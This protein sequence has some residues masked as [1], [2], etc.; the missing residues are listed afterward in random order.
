M[1]G[2]ESDLLPAPE[3]LSRRRESDEPRDRR[4][5]P[6]AGLDDDRP[7]RDR[8]GQ[9]TERGAGEPRASADLRPRDERHVERPE[10]TGQRDACEGRRHDPGGRSRCAR[11][12][13]DRE[14]DAGVGR[15]Q[16]RERCRDQTLA[17]EA[18]HVLQT[19]LSALANEFGVI[20]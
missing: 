3:G 18:S 1:V 9:G 20:L 14:H 2:R 12:R 5:R 15:R 11:G 6:R 8:E 7:H 13:L 4:H 19:E 16:T 17:A 10:H